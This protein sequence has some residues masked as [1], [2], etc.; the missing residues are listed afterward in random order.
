MARPL[1]V[2]ERLTKMEGEA[3]LRF[4]AEANSAGAARMGAAERAR[5][6]ARL[7]PPGFLAG[8]HVAKSDRALSDVLAKKAN[9]PLVS[10]FLGLLP[11]TERAALVDERGR[12][13]AA[14]VQRFERA[15]FAYALPG[16]SGERLARLIY[17]GGEAIE[18]VGT[19]L[20][21][22][23]PGLARLEDRI[24][25]GGSDPE[26]RL[27]DDLAAAVEKMR[28]IRK[29]DLSV[30]DYLRQH[31]FFPQLTP[32]QEQILVQL[33]ARR[34]SGRAV[35]GLLNAYTAAALKTP[36]PAQASLPGQAQR[37]L[38]PTGLFRAALKEVGGEWVDMSRWSAAQQAMA[39]F[40]TMP[41]AEIEKLNPS[42]QQLGMLVASHT[43]ES[44]KKKKPR[45]INWQER[46]QVPS[47]QDGPPYTVA[48]DDK[49]RWGCSCPGWVYQRK[50]KEAAAGWWRDPCR[51]IEQIQARE[52]VDGKQ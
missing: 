14:G 42:Q 25:A 43:P 12:L 19:G 24:R 52:K 51:H 22:A 36:S 4:I 9:A 21:M 27:G 45:G 31:K 13:S 34:R 16:R 50:P 38:T 29:Q 10:R 17:E 46:W 33:D 40:E 35:A 44:V 15:V 37:P 41:A 11:K 2:R 28:D 6:E 7:L 23:L 47:G 5:A 30:N 3:Q 32:L 1:L 39:G 49:G 18:R 20:K 26:L 48:R 8:L